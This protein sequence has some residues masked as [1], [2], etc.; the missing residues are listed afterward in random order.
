MDVPH[1]VEHVSDDVGM[2]DRQLIDDERAAWCVIVE[3]IRDQ[4]LAGR[5]CRA[6]L[7]VMRP[8][9]ARASIDAFTDSRKVITPEAK[10]AEDELAHLSSVQRRGQRFMRRPR[11]GMNVELDASSDHE[12]L[13]LARYAPWSINV[14]LYDDHDNHIG[15]LHDC[16]FDITIKLS[17]DEAAGVAADLEGFLHLETYARWRA[18]GSR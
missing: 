2:K 15:T 5:A 11:R 17:P 3:E 8:R 16:A 13:L 6:V 12:W 9:I 10:A 14:D 18:R 1:R 4:A 7:D